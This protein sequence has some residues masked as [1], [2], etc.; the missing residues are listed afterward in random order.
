[1]H[2][3]RLLQLTVSACVLLASTLSAAPA[4]AVKET[5]PADAAAEAFFKL[6]DAKGVPP[7]AERFNQIIESGKAFL[8]QYP[9]HGKAGTVIQ[10][11]AT[12]DTTM[13]GKELAAMRNYWGTLLGYAAIGAGGDGESEDARA[14]LLALGAAAAGTE[15][16]LA[17]SRPA[18][19]KYREKIDQLAESPAAGRF[20]AE[21][22]RAYLK[23]LAGQSAAQALPQAKKLLAHPDKKVAA[24][25]REELNLIELAITPLELKF[26]T[27]DGR[28][29]DVGEA[30][31]KALYVYFWSLANETSVKEVQELKA[32]YFDH[33]KKNL[34]IIA[35]AHDTDAAA[36]A[37][38]V[39][40]KK[41]QFPV[42]CDGTGGKDELSRKLNAKKLPVA[43]V[44]DNKGI[45]VTNTIRP[46]K[47]LVAIK[48]IMGIK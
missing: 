39:K 43:A 42:L 32:T 19:D 13:P 1:M 23:L 3:P 38:F 4:A 8:A 16:R 9:T 41:I 33:R 20:L 28:E 2:L 24:M 36:V 48:A 26:T 18:L 46:N 10:S 35:V 12:F 22:E 29:F 15:F 21:Q 5:T 45:Y 7:S 11:L 14:A 40:D 6:R 25:A 47:L 27:V 31:G 34:E 17:P 30:R 37:K 44:F